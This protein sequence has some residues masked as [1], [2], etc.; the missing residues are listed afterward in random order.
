MTTRPG[1]LSEQ[2]STIA[3]EY[4]P[5]A[6]ATEA[7]AEDYLTRLEDRDRRRAEREGH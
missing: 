2:F 6:L 1:E 7:E 4:A 3:Q 5:R